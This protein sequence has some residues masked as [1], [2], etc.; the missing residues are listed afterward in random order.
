MHMWYL[1][2]HALW[3]FRKMN[4]CTPWHYIMQQKCVIEVQWKNV[5][6][7][8]KFWADVATAKPP[9][10]VTQ[11]YRTGYAYRFPVLLERSRTRR[12]VE[13]PA[14]ATTFYQFD[15]DGVHPALRQHPFAQRQ[16]QERTR[17]LNTPNTY[18]K[19]SQEQASPGHQRTTVSL[20]SWSVEMIRGELLDQRVSCLQW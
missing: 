5:K 14:T 3:L 9:P 18:Q 15:D 17:W 12:E 13:V 6:I 4:P 11:G 19:V 7:S 16:Q 1:R 8:L 20:Y 10:F 2:S